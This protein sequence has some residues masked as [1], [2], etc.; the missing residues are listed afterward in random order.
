MTL[1]ALRLRSPV[2]TPCVVA[3]LLCV[4]I[5][6]FGQRYSQTN[7]VA[8]TPG[9]AANTDPNLVNPW[10]I[11][12]SATSP[13]WVADN[14]KGVSTLYNGSGT[15]LPLVVTIPPPDNS[16]D[17][18]APTGAAFNATN[19]FAVN[20]G[21][22]SLPA[23]FL[24]VTE[25]GTISGWNPKVDATHAVIAVDNSA[26]GAVYKGM[27]LAKTD[28]GDFLYATNFHD[29]TIEVYDA[30]FTLKRTITDDNLPTRFA[31]FGIRN[32]N[33]KL[34]VT[35]ARQDQAKHDDF[36]GPNQGFVD[37]ID[38]NTDSV[39]RVIS[40]KGLNSPWGIALAPAN[41][42]KFSND[43]LIG[44]FGDGTISAYTTGGKFLGQFQNSSGKTLSIDGLWTIT[45]G[46]GGMAGMTNELFFSAGPNDEQN[47]L[48]GNLTP[49]Q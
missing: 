48:F 32:I 5:G 4:S 19:D 12:F 11:A 22:V 47:G 9:V 15:P 20:K 29:G 14:G 28:H 40:R 49:A 1:S 31:P 36:A 2:T 24:F 3:V 23:T 46:N 6:A 30:H 21:G 34:Y 38:P 43:L 26:R 25:D 27:A 16:T 41:F 44:S 42:G 33:G 8:D 7:L 45:F 35:F 10:G 37:V 17:S 39:Q 13:F 18:S